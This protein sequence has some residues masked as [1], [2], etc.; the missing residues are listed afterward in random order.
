MRL[1][2]LVSLITR[3]VLHTCECILAMWV[4]ALWIHSSSLDLDKGVRCDFWKVSWK[5]GRCALLPSHQLDY[6]V[7]EGFKQP[8][9]TMRKEGLYCGWRS[10]KTGKNLQSSWN[11]LQFLTSIFLLHAWEIKFYLVWGTGIW[12][13]FL[14]GGSLTAKPN[15]NWYFP[16]SIVCVF[17]IHLWDQ[18]CT[19]F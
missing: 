19:V 1:H 9:W 11:C 2:F 8:A 15:P 13:F 17:P 18:N 7:I 5:E 16:I 4:T 14:G 3:C 6:N 12:G 10:S